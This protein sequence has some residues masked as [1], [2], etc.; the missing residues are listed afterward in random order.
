MLNRSLTHPQNPQLQINRTNIYICVNRSASHIQSDSFTDTHTFEIQYRFVSDGDGTK[1]PLSH[2]LNHPTY[3]TPS[4]SAPRATGYRSRSQHSSFQRTTT[5]TLSSQFRPHR[6]DSAHAPPPSLHS[7]VYRPGY[8][9]ATLLINVPLSSLQTLL[10]L[11]SA[12]DFILSSR[13][14]RIRSIFNLYLGSSSYASLISF[15]L[16]PSPSLPRQS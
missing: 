10:G 13:I 3:T 2:L 1:S 8:S 5:G 11:A 6:Q 12:R 16:I 14:P 7:G 4:T 9:S 15:S